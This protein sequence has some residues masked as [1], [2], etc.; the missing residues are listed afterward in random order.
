[1]ALVKHI[2]GKKV[3]V[4]RAFDGETL[5]LKL[6]EVIGST[7]KIEGLLNHD[8]ELATWKLKTLDGFDP[9]YN[10]PGT[11]HPMLALGLGEM[12]DELLQETKKGSTVSG[13]P[14]TQPIRVMEGANEIEISRRK[15]DAQ[16]ALEDVQNQFKSR[17]Q[18]V[19]MVDMPSKDGAIPGSNDGSTFLWI[20]GAVV[21]LA[22]YNS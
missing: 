16:D 2:E 10:A 22:Y 14:R 8:S 19:V 5:D 3:E 12:D 13:P 21:I 18:Q 7:S 20:A 15:T 6:D 17:T 11:V 1:M 4:V 9:H